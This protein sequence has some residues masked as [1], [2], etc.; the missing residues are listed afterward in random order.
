MLKFPPRQDRRGGFD[1]DEADDVAGF[2]DEVD[3]LA[4]RFAPMIDIRREAAI[5]AR[6][7]NFG[8]DPGFKEWSTQRMSDDSIGPVTVTMG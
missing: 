2:A 4:A 7:Q 6:L 8:S 1:S 3:L 5:G